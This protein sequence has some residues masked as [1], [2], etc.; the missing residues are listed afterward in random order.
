MINGVARGEG[1]AEQLSH[2][3]RWHLAGLLDQGVQPLH[4]AAGI[5]PALAG[6]LRSAVSR[7]VRGDHPVRRRQFG[8]DPHPMRRVRHGAVQQNDRRP[9]TALQDGGRDAGQEQSALL[10]GHVRQEPPAGLHAWDRF[11]APLKRSVLCRSFDLSFDHGVLLFVSARMIRWRMWAA[12][13]GNPPIRTLAW[14]G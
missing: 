13:R 1:A 12:L 14:R 8:D 5:D 3:S 10:Y 6:Y 4:D 9:I 7:Q 11:P 2:Q